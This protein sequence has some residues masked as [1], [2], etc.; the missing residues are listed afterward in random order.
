MGI[1]A[2]LN[3]YNARYYTRKEERKQK[4]EQAIAAYR[5]SAH[6]VKDAR[7]LPSA[8]SVRKE[9]ALPPSGDYNKDYAAMLK[10]THIL[11]AGTTGSGKSVVLNGIMHTA[12]ALLSPS[13]AEFILVDPKEVELTDYEN[14]PHVREILN[15]EDEVAEMLER[16]YDEMMER[17]HEMRSMGVKKYTGKAIYVIIDELAD[18]MTGQ[19]SKRIRVALQRL[20][21]KSRAASIHFIAATQAPN[22]RIIPA[23]IV[24]NFTDRIALRC[25][26]SIE[27]RQILNVAGAEKIKGHGKAMYLSPS[28]GIKTINIP[29]ISEESLHERIAYWE[30]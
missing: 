7:A 14:L 28:D 22:R 17:Y 21:Q 4:I 5:E 11:I 23:E 8:P 3:N 6:P 18:L 29:L 10:S 16:L 27:S 30:R 12:L 9:H 26:S 24:L 2:W 20:L 13:E 25:L 15:D 19:Q 1:N